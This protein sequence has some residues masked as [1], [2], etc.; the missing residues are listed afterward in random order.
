MVSFL[1]DWMIFKFFSKINDK[2]PTSRVITC[3][4]VL[5]K[6][7]LFNWTART[8]GNKYT[9][10]NFKYGLGKKVLYKKSNEIPDLNQ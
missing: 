6:N 3:L 2:S 5:V 10:N 9:K 8:T 1:A 4:E 7:G